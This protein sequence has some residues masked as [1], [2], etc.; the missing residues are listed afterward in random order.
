MQ[1]R[2]PWGWV[3]C[4]TVAVASCIADDDRGA[5]T[6]AIPPYTAVA[7][8][9]LGD[10]LYPVLAG[11]TAFLIR[12][13][14]ATGLFALSR[15]SLAS[16]QLDT[17]VIGEGSLYYNQDWWRVVSRP[18]AFVM[19]LGPNAAVVDASRLR[20]V[21][22]VP[23]D[24]PVPFG[25]DNFLTVSSPSDT[26]IML[27]KHRILGNGSTQTTDSTN[28]VLTSRDTLVELVRLFSTQE[29]TGVPD[30]DDRVLIAYVTSKETS[31]RLKGRANI[32]TLTLNSSTPGLGPTLM[33]GDSSIFRFGVVQRVYTLVG[34]RLLVVFHNMLLCVDSET[35]D[36][37]WTTQLPR[38]MLTSKLLLMPDERAVW[39]GED[40]RGYIL[41]TTGG[42]IVESFDASYTPSR[43]VECGG[44]LYYVGGGRLYRYPLKDV[45]G[46]FGVRQVGPFS[47]LSKAI[48][49]NDSAIV[50]QDRDSIYIYR[51]R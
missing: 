50:L 27:Y 45:A 5:L 8:P 2:Y 15:L 21:Q 31:G 34:S 12:A 1:L 24:H 51:C 42:A 28:V 23:G 4:S 44:A 9:S 39:L 17:L 35:M 48:A 30:P 20:S 33:P 3:V 36:T 6:A 16:A 32:R 43:P 46:E 38:Q 25:E 29:H 41:E 13:D 11:D 19:R 7:A 47:T 22:V 14:Y 49:A 18:A 10:N 40:G 37:V 26:S